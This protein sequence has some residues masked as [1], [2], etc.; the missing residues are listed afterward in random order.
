M[1][2]ANNIPGAAPEFPLLLSLLSAFEMTS[3]ASPLVAWLGIWDETPSESAKDFWL[4]VSGWFL[5]GPA[6]ALVPGWVSGAAE[7][8]PIEEKLG[9]AD[10]KPLEA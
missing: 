5:E 9:R 6:G 2:Q 7:E 10:E 1:E 8:R 3:E 4:F